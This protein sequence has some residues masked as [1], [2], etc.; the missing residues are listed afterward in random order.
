[1]WGIR[2][3]DRTFDYAEYVERALDAGRAGNRVFAAR[4]MGGTIDEVTAKLRAVYRD[5]D[6]S[7]F[8]LI[9][10]AFGDTQFVYLRRG[11]V[12]AQAVSWLRAEQTNRWVDAI[13]SVLVH[14]EGVAS[15]D[16]GALDELCRTIHDHNAAWEDWFAVAGVERYSVVYEDLDRDPVGVTLRVLDFLGL[17]LPPAGAIQGRTRRQADDRNAEW[18]RRYRGVPSR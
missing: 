2:R 18:I 15:F 7:A 8:D 11:D 1:M 14:H 3:A 6:A 4:L 5:A 9:A 12:V 16:R 13:D 10:R 17:E